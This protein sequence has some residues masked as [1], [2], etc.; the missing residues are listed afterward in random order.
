MDKDKATIHLRRTKEGDLVVEIVGEDGEVLVSRNFGDMT[1]EEIGRVLDA[2][3]DEYPDTV[4]H[5]IELTG[6]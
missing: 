2:L 4:I 1:D 3:R 5:P 6:N